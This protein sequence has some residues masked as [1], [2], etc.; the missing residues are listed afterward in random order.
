[1]KQLF[2]L[3]AIGLFVGC[4][5]SGGNG[6]I[7]ASGYIEATEVRVGTKVA[8]KLQSLR[9]A[10]G[11]TVQNGQEI[12]RIDP[13][14]HL[15]A[16]DTAKAERDQFQADLRGTEKDLKRMDDLFSSGSGT[17]KARD[18]AKTRFDMTSARLAA[19]KAKVAQLDQQISDTSIKSPLDGLVTQKL[20]EE[21]ELLAMGSTLAIVTDVKNCWLTAYVGEPDLPK[22][23]VGQEADVTT[24]SADY[25]RKGKITYISSTAEFTPK[26]VQTKDERIK[27]VYKIKISMNNNDLVFKPGMPAQSRVDALP[28][29]K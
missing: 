13:V 6:T 1:M 5:K 9:V 3:C 26:N 11:S 24:D 4:S 25:T 14:D 17:A 10:E 7:L 20:V 28:A 15:L 27:L 12:A 21:G 19:S 22:I 29:G 2:L 23:R 16:L 8:G 18:D